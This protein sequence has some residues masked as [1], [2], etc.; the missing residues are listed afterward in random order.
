MGQNLAV[1][2]RLVQ[3]VSAKKSAEEEAGAQKRQAGLQVEESEVFAEQT[4]EEF[5]KF[6]R[7]QKL[8]F[9]KSG[10]RLEGSPLLVL[11]ETEAE[12]QRRVTA[13]R[14]RGRALGGLGR[15]RANILRRT[16]RSRLLSSFA[17]A[18]QT[19]SR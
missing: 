4:A 13:I 11:Q 7:K 8:L 16:G 19:A 1:F 10:I 2:A 18:Q 5:R 12:G 15:T 17:Q 14:K 6:K 9:L 3:G